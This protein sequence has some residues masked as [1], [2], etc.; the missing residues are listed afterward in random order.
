LRRPDGFAK[1]DRNRG[2]VGR[3]RGAQYGVGAGRRA[4]R[5][6]CRQCGWTAGAWVG[7]EFE[8]PLVVDHGRFARAFGDHPPLGDAVRYTVGWFRGHPRLAWVPSVACPCAYRE[9][10]VR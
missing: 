9:R 4:W 2:E 1:F 3:A 8:E 5:A 10:M 6:G 7:G